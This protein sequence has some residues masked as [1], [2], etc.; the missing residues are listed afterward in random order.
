[1]S[2]P[3]RPADAADWRQEVRIRPIGVVH[4]PRVTPT[5]DNW[6]NVTSTIELD[7]GRMSEA[8]VLGLERFSHL[9]I[10]YF[11]HM[12]REDDVET[13]AR[14]P[15]NRTDWPKVGIL[16]QRAKRRP[17]RIGVSCCDLVS[18]EGLRLTVRGLDAVDGTPVLDVKP[19]FREFGPR[20]AVRQPEWVSEVMSEYYAG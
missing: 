2:E 10:V 15:R 20:S 9:Q 6:G 7:G 13:G 12:V 1:M 8:S 19:Y 3:E 17:N 5:D 14:H 18:V 16:A 11:L 4:S